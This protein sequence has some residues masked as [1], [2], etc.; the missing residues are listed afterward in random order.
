MEIGLSEVGLLVDLEVVD[1]HLRGRGHL[2]AFVVHVAHREH[3]RLLLSSHSAQVDGA[4]RA[5]V[6]SQIH[7]RAV[8]EQS[9]AQL[10][11][12]SLLDWNLVARV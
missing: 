9:E 5:V 3:T 8:R 1:P 10:E 11:C 4:F 2:L 6:R 12:N 7:A